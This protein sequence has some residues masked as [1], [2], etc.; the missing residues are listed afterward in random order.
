MTSKL[1]VIYTSKVFCKAEIDTLIATGKIGFING[2]WRKLESL[3]TAYSFTVIRN[4][5]RYS[6]AM[7]MEIEKWFYDHELYKLKTDPN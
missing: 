1:G 5:E 7:I 6:P 4:E 3:D 2:E